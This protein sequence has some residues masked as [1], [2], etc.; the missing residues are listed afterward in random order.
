M[1]LF[2]KNNAA[3]ANDQPPRN[4][5]SS[6]LFRVLAIGYVAYLCIQMVQIY[7]EGGPEAPSLTMLI[8]SIVGLGAGS[9]ILGILT[10]RE[11]KRNKVKYDAYMA[12]MKA[13]AKAAREAEEAMEAALKAED[14]YYEALE[15]AQVAAEA[16][17]N[18]EE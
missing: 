8:L 17:E 15:A 10:Y 3:E 12:E 2:K 16:E 14:E 13:E 5:N 11:W 6:V 7:L 4:P 18:T 1:A 9:L